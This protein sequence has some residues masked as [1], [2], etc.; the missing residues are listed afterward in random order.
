MIG[1]QEKYELHANIA[2][3]FENV[4]NEEVLK[5]WCYKAARSYGDVSHGCFT[6]ANFSSVVM[7]EMKYKS[8]LTGDIVRMI[9]TARPWLREVDSCQ[10]QIILPLMWQSKP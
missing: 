1:K 7:E 10:Y 5:Y 4:F 3:R 8:V 9:L 2:M 6:N